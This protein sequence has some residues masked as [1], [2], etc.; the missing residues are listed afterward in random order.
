MITKLCAS[1]GE[2]GAEKGESLCLVCIMQFDKRTISNSRKNHQSDSK[3]KDIL[4]LTK[5]AR[6]SQ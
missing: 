3:K 2:R 5:P 6:G 1:C 4:S